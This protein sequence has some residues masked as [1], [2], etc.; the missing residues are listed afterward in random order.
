MQLAYVASRWLTPA[1][2][3][4]ISD[5]LI[6]LGYWSIAGALFYVVRRDRSDRFRRIYGF[7]AAFIFVG[8]LSHLVEVWTAWN[9]HAW[10]AAALTGTAAVL[11]IIAAAE[12]MAMIP[13]GLAM[14]TPEELERLNLRL[15]G[16]CSRDAS[17]SPRSASQ[18]VSWR[19]H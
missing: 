2:F 15:G 3:D 9:P 19:T 11:S 8:G 12:L 14:R 18:L 7:F 6:G 13:A 17:R 1:R 10:L 16:R 5:A 4:L